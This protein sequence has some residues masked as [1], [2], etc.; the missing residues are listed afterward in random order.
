MDKR[1]YMWAEAEYLVQK[2]LYLLYINILL[3]ENVALL[4][5]KYVFIFKQS[6]Q[7][8]N[9]ILD[10]DSLHLNYSRLRENYKV[11]KYSWYF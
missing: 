1:Y 2:N 8:V 6:L 3:S 7:Y 11:C 9:V 5:L 4:V 10:E